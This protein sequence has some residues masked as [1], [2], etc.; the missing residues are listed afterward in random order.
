VIDM[1]RPERWG[2]L[3][4]STAKP[5]SAVFRAD[6][7]RH[8]RDQLHRVY[9]AQR[10]HRAKT[11]S[12]AESLDALKLDASLFPKALRIERTRSTF[13]AE[14]PAQGDP[15]SRWVIAQDSWIRKVS[16][17]KGKR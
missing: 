1:H 17:P 4:F 6:P 9:Y 8:I 3:Q 5:G 15:A 13:E 10:E 2:Y 12:Y 7:E 11:G 16:P 14:L